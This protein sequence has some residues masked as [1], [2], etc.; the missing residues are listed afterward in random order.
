[1]PFLRKHVELIQPKCVVL[2]GGTATKVLLNLDDGILKLRGHIFECHKNVTVSM[3]AKSLTA[4]DHVTMKSR[5]EAA[6]TGRDDNCILAIPT[7]H[8]SYIMRSPGQKQ[9]VWRD[10]LL[11][12]KILMNLV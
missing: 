12:K 9:S 10:M 5:V 7:L 8:P 2:L 4:D 3:K 1:M 11:L 6:L